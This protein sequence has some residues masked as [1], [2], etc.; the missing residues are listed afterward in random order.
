[1]GNW[2]AASFPRT[3]FTRIQV[4]LE[5]LEGAGDLAEGNGI[6]IVQRGRLVG[7]QALAIDARGVGTIQ[8]GQGKAVSA[9]L[10][11]GMHT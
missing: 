8:V 3:S 1:M 10:K 9:M 5:L 7:L 11:G 6:A 4:F 2:P